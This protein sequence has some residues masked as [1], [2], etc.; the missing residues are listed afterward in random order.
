MTTLL[1]VT[2]HALYRVFVNGQF[3]GH[4][5]ARAGYGFYRVDEWTLTPR[6]RAG[7]NVVAIEVAGYNANSFYLLDE[8]SFLQAEVVAGDKVLASTA[9]AGAPFEAAILKTRLQKVQRYSFQ[10]PF[11]EVWR[12]TA[13][14]DNWRAS[15]EVAI[16]KTKC[17]VVGSKSLLPRRVPYPTFAVRPPVAH[18]ATGT[19]QKGDVPQGAWKD[20]SLTGIGP[21]LGGFPE[22]ELDTIPTLELQ[23]VKN[24]SSQPLQ[25]PYTSKPTVTLGTNTFATLDFGVNYTG[26]VGAKVTVRNTTR[27]F[28]TFDEIL[29]DGDVDFKRLGCVNIVLYELLP[30]TYEVE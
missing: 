17:S 16:E 29:T 25:Q 19:V 27:L 11:S 22:K 21:K 23:A 5:P 28:L 10:R 4:G 1:R 24:V 12:L 6:L 14:S 13:G 3:A 8:P 20:R 26:F 9:G 18:V 15:P 7:A 2:G 30:G